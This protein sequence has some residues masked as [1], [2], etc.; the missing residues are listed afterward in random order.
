LNHP[1]HCH[2]C[3]QKEWLRPSSCFLC[4]LEA[5]RVAR[6]PAAPL[7]AMTRR[8][9]FGRLWEPVFAFKDFERHVP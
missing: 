6:Q 9:S 4:E 8:G 3:R 2:T 1:H 5:T 7:L